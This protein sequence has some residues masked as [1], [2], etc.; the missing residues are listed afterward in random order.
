MTAAVFLPRHTHREIKKSFTVLCDIIIIFAEDARTMTPVKNAF[1][2]CNSGKERALEFYEEL[3]A[4][5]P[6]KGVTLVDSAEN[7]D[8]A[9][10]IGGDGT[11]L[12]FARSH[13]D[14][15]RPIIAVNM[16]S[17]GFLTDVRTQECSRMIELLLSGE[18]T[19]EKRNFLEV[20]MDGERHYAL[21]DVV[22]SKSGT[23][24]RMVTVR[25]HANGNFLNTY[26][27]D[28]IIIASPTGSTAYSLSC[29]GP[30]MVPGLEALLITPIAVHNLNARPIVLSKKDTVTLSLNEG[31][32]A[33][34]LMIDGQSFCC[35]T[36]E[37]RVSV[38]LSEKYIL[39][40]LFPGR[41]FFSVLREKLRWGEDPV[42]SG[43]NK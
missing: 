42:V 4:L 37:D 5:L 38:R 12:N 6:R 36:K 9:I 8:F 27:A 41:T 22:L 30:I 3:C 7:S 10:V 43:D 23:T 16:G 11:L 26:R 1:M 19:I 35:F 28:G 29:G 24:S 13:V 31:E 33:A 25:V 34:H 21:N 2:V 14:Y 18:Y 32:Q 40:V 20:E 39:P 17:L 15:I